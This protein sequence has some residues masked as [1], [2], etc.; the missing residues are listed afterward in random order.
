MTPDEIRSHPLFTKLTERK[1]TFI[2]TL[3]TNN[4]DKIAAAHA[5]WNC[6]GDESARTL[7][8][9]ALQDESVAFLVEQYFGRDPLARAV[10]PRASS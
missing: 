1:Q 3:L 5:A 6:N 8:N 4:N 9:R 10:H 7:A 2:N